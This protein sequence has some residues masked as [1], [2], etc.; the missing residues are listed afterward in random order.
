MGISYQKITLYNNDYFLIEYTQAQERGNASAVIH[1][2]CSSN[3]LCNAILPPANAKTISATAKPSATH[4]LPSPS[5]PASRRLP[6]QSRE[7]ER[8]TSPPPPPRQPRSTRTEGAPRGMSGQR[9][10]P[11]PRSPSIPNSLARLLVPLLPRRPCFPS[12]AAPCWCC[13]AGC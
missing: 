2:V 8:P 6:C 10:P 9:Q 4:L 7:E 11:P 12:G 5:S 13:D 3:C 1:T